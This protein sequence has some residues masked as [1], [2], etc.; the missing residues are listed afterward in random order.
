[1]S[2]HD[3]IRSNLYEYIT[4]DTAS[5][6]SHIPYNITIIEQVGGSLYVYI[7]TKSDDYV[8]DFLL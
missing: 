5:T 2:W 3:T 8:V 6:A 7:H 4:S 1:M